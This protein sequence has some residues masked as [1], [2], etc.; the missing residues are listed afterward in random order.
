MAPADIPVPSGV[1]YGT[2]PA[3]ATQAFPKQ[4]DRPLELVSGQS[5]YLAAFVDIIQPATRCVFEAP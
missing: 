4:G 3:G 1:T 2:V 5:Y